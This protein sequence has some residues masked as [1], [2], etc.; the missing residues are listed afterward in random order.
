MKDG[1]V[2]KEFLPTGHGAHAVRGP[3][4]ADR[5]AQGGAGEQAARGHPA[6]L[7]LQHQQPL[8]ISPIQSGPTGF[9]PISGGIQ[10]DPS[11]W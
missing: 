11:G 3:L 7:H 1:V 6:K 2:V 9:D 10:G 4:P 5:A 8:G